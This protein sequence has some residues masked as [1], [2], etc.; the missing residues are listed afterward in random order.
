MGQGEVRADLGAEQGDE[1]RLTEAGKPGQQ[2]AERKQPPM[3]RDE[4]QITQVKLRK[5]A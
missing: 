2:G 4:S 3:V 1:E 5:A